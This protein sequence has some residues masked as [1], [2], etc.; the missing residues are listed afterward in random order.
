MA[1]NTDPIADVYRRAADSMA[2]MLPPD[3]RAKCERILGPEASSRE[4]WALYDTT[5][6]HLRHVAEVG[7]VAA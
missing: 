1:N 5:L 6:S 4:R 2:G 7:N 3:V